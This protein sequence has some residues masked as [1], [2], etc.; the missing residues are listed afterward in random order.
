[1]FT[2]NCPRCHGQQQFPDN[3]AGR[4][5]HC[6][7][8]GFGFTA[9][10]DEEASGPPPLY[11][12]PPAS[13]GTV[14][15]VTIL[16]MIG[17]V[18]VVA[19]V[20]AA[21]VHSSSNEPVRVARQD[22]RVVARDNQLVLE[23]HD[24]SPSPGQFLFGLAGLTILGLFMIAVYFTPSFIAFQRQHHQRFA[25]LMLNFFAGW[26]GLAWAGALVW[27]FTSIE[28]REHH[29]FHYAATGGES[30]SAEAKA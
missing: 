28:S 14:A 16:G 15:A 13:R 30:P 27:A 25:I 6:P 10:T 9:L 5:V 7:R 11:F 8:C 18:A 21:M 22:V 17:M 3:A 12:E 29:H 2:L 23:P 26:T 24:S 4:W 1:M 19:V 20:I